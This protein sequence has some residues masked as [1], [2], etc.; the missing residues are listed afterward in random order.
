MIDCR[1]AG[2]SVQEC[3]DKTSKFLGCELDEKYYIIK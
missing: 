1:V 3:I 2:N